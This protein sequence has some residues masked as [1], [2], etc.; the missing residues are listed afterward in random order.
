MN[1]AIETTLKT[2]LRY[3]SSNNILLNSQKIKIMLFSQRTKDK[4][5]FI[6]TLNG[7]QIRHSPQLNILGNLVTDNLTR[8][9][10]VEKIVLP[11]LR[12]RVRTLGLTS[13]YLD[14]KF[15]RTYSNS[16]FCIGNMGRM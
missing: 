16:N 9:S 10:H 11:G 3:T 4:T 7:K 1:E 2:V 15:K 5:D 14:S 6:F 8:D 13:K 12:N